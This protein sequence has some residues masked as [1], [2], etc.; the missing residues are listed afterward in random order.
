MRRNRLALAAALAVALP[1]AVLAQEAP[2][3]AA[4]AL[5]PPAVAQPLNAATRPLNAPRPALPV[6]PALAPRPA[7]PVR[8][9]LAPRPAITGSNTAMQAAIQNAVAAAL[10]AERSRTTGGTTAT[11]AAPAGNI[12]EAT[13]A[14]RPAAP[15]RAT[16]LNLR[17]EGAA[18]APGSAPASGSPWTLPLVLLAG[19]AGLGLFVAK[20]RPD[21]LQ[22]LRAQAGLPTPGW[23]GSL[24][25]LRRTGLGMRNELVVVELNGQV[26]LLGVTPGSI[27][28]LAVLPDEDVA[29]EEAAPAKEENHAL[30][31]RFAAILDAARA[32]PRKVERAEK[33]PAED[34]GVE[35]QARGLLGL[36]TSE[37]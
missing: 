6:R 10:A 27:Q 20:R 8:P 32:Q 33:R 37:G 26:L 36:R 3:A 21:L 11:N 9:A 30:G 1:G 25:V 35:E 12:P 34:L 28:S 31:E 24:N 4:P 13:N 16:P 19:L 2:A 17:G 15:T 22:S 14:P 7:L 5:T 18:S 23:N 29:H